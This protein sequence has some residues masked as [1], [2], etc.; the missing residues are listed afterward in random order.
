[1]NKFIQKISFFF[2]SDWPIMWEKHKIYKKKNAIRSWKKLVGNQMND[3]ER[4][5]ICEM[6]LFFLLLIEC[7]KHIPM[8]PT[9]PSRNNICDLSM[10]YENCNRVLRS[11]RR[12]KFSYVKGR[13][14][15]QV[16]ARSS[17]YGWHS[18]VQKRLQCMYCIVPKKKYITL[19]R[20]GA[21]FVFIIYL[22]G[23]NG[24]ITSDKQDEMKENL[25]KSWIIILLQI[26]IVNA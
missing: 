18:F 20:S 19:Q 24:E 3:F 5:M 7:I 9:R 23:M 4:L 14:S 13:H 10:L 26:V 16:I 12:L 6:I 22:K 11:I 17:P 21:T 2:T 25:K 1:M 15:R 8:S